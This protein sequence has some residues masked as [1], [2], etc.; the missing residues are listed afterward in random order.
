[1]ASKLTGI[2]A[3][4]SY[5]NSNGTIT[6]RLRTYNVDTAFPEGKNTPLPNRPY[7]QQLGGV[8]PENSQ[9]VLTLD[10]TGNAPVQ[11]DP[12]ST[13]EIPARR[14][15]RDAIGEEQF[16]F[17]LMDFIPELASG[18]VTLLPGKGKNT[19]AYTLSQVERILLGQPSESSTNMN[20]SSILME[21]MKP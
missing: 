11:L 2:K 9:V 13:V 7:I 8:F 1:M 14:F 12:T 19:F 3:S 20:N 4:I 10:I 17:T 5:S 15:V 18:A 6:N 16:T 21:M